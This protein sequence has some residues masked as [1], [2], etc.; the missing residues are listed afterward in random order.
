MRKMFD[1]LFGNKEMRVRLT[2]SRSSGS[3]QNSASVLNV[4]VSTGGDAWPG[5]CWQ[6]HD[7]V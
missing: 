5:C 4:F 6:D 1:K 2:N 3:S 7:L